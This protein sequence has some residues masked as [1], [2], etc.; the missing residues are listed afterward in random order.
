MLFRVGVVQEAGNKHTSISA[1]L[2][3][4]IYPNTNVFGTISVGMI[5]YKYCRYQGPFGMIP[6]NTGNV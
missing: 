3:V 6:S 1:S 2:Q 4:S 5:H